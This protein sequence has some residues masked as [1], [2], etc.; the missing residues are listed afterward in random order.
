M[1]FGH[2]PNACQASKHTVNKI[3]QLTNYTFIVTF[4]NLSSLRIQV[5][6]KNPLRNK[7]KKI[8]TH[9]EALADVSLT[10]SRGY[11]WTRSVVHIAGHVPGVLTELYMDM[12]SNPSRRYAAT[13][14]EITGWR[15]RQY[16]GVERD[17]MTN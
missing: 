11:S 15:R 10:V 4:V 1:P 16:E 8:E 5:N 2:Q 17:K 9:R 14:I 6:K 7:K 3:T 12:R 13:V